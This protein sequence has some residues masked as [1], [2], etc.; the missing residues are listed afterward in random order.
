VNH[1]LGHICRCSKSLINDNVSIY[2]FNDLRLYLATVWSCLYIGP[3]I[4]TRCKY[5]YRLLL[6]NLVSVQS[7]S[8]MPN[9]ILVLDDDLEL[10]PVYRLYSCAD[11]MRRAVHG[12]DIC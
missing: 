1:Q 2:K 11:I 3:N 12:E 4:C 8:C 6:N 10:L 5:L 9:I 7:L